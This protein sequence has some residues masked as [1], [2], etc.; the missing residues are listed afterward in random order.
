MKYIWLLIGLLLP[1]HL[2]AQAEHRIGG[3]VQ[4]GYQDW[5]KLNDMKIH[6]GVSTALGAVYEY[7]QNHFLLQAGVSGAY[8]YTAWQCDNLYTGVFP[9][10]LDTDRDICS[11]HYQF[12]E[13]SDQMHL[14]DIVPHIMAGGQW[15][16]FY[17][18]VG[19]KAHMNVYGRDRTS[20]FLTTE[21]EYENLI[22]PLQT[23]DN[24]YFWSHYSI[25][26][27][28]GKKE[29]GYK[30]LFSFTGECGIEI[31]RWHISQSEGYCTNRLALFAEYGV[32]GLY[33]DHHMPVVDFPISGN[34]L[35]DIQRE[36]IRLYP[37]F[38]SEQQTW[39][40]LHAVSVGIR[41]TVLFSFPTKK[42]CMCS[43]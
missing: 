20:A 37:L 41:W 12:S 16:I 23:M 29:V 24:H 32:M 28:W 34:R 39:K 26:D 9:D 35:S 21:G 33:N 17:F 22:S 40:D 4:V 19:I 38:G 30:G 8:S 6:G 42:S 11:Y 27:E 15:N 14:L 10:M 5:T 2:V 36:K 3:S 43:R 7:K 13:K 18:L 31:P 1:L 25:T